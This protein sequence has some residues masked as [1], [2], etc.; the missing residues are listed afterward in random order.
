[1]I[2]SQVHEANEEG[3]GGNRVGG[4]TETGERGARHD[5]KEG[6]PQVILASQALRATIHSVSAP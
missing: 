1:V 3:A 6:A 2:V 5:D 4:A